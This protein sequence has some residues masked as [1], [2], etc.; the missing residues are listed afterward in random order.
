MW[1]ELEL[2]FRL[3]FFAVHCFPSARLLQLDDK[4]LIIMPTQLLVWCFRTSA[5]CVT[6]HL[7]RNKNYI[8]YALRSDTPSLHHSNTVTNGC[9][10]LHEMQGN[11]QTAR[12]ERISTS[13]AIQIYRFDCVMSWRPASNYMSLHWAP[14]GRVQICNIKIYC[15]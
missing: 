13:A 5:G 9:L 7:G 11:S 12:V 10:C 1:N 4:V 2:L 3:V 14:Y 6:T 15:R 8:N